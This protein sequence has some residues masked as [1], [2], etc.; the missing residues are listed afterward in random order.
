MVWQA[1]GLKYTLLLIEAALAVA[2]MRSV[3]PKISEAGSKEAVGDD[4]QPSSTTSTLKGRKLQA[5]QGAIGG[6][7]EF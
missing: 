5:Q 2:E 1:D 4:P 3:M 7:S 6:V